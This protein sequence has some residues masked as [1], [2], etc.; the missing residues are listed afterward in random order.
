MSWW[1]AGIAMRR[2]RTRAARAA[3][4]RAGHAAR[5]AHIPALTAEV[6]SASRVLNTARGAPWLGRGEERLLLLEEVEALL[7]SKAL[8][9]DAC[10]YVVRDEGKV[11]LVG[12]APRVVRA[13]PR[14]GRSLGRETCRGMLSLHGH[15]ARNAPMNRIVPDCGSNWGGFARRSRRWPA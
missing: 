4:T 1:L 7:A 12:K 15:S 2:L 11:G 5:A 3:L 9:V 10:R 8:V 14:A 13:R 6:E